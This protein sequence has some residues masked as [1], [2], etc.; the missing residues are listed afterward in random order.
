M[1]RA[2]RL[3]LACQKFGV[4]AQGKLAHEVPGAPQ[5]RA[6]RKELSFLHK[7][8][9]RHVPSAPPRSPAVT[10]VTRFVSSRP[11]TELGVRPCVRA[12]APFC[13]VMF[14]QSGFCFF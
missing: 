2:Q 12:P 3:V 1:A 11:F 8:N 5:S 14:Y 13:L 7:E 10:A 4:S 9:C 6:L